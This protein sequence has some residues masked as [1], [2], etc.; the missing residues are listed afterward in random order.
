MVSRLAEIEAL[1]KR[2]ALPFNLRLPP[3]EAALVNSKL[4]DTE[5]L[6]K[7][8][9]PV[10][11]NVPDK[12]EFPLTVRLPPI[13]AKLVTSRLVEMLAP[14]EKMFNAVQVF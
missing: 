3:I 2:S 9:N 7:V 6:E 8:D 1:D 12:V 14:A 4:L 5:A 13:L 11:A 10:T